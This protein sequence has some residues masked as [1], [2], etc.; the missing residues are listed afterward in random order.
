MQ[1][2]F[3]KDGETE[4]LTD[5]IIQSKCGKTIVGHS[6]TQVMSLQIDKESVVVMLNSKTMG[7]KNNKSSDFHG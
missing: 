3:L 5:K 1:L 6:R 2:V 4:F 7:I